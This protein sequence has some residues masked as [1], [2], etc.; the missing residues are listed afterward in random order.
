MQKLKENGIL[1]RIWPDKGG[2][3]KVLVKLSETDKKN[4]ELT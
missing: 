3:R 1:Q 4:N 2:Y